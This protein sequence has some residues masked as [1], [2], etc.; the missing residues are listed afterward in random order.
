MQ[1]SDEGTEGPHLPQEAKVEMSQV[2]PRQDAGTCAERTPRLA[3]SDPTSAPPDTVPASYARRRSATR[4]TGDSG[5][6]DGLADRSD[7]Q[8]YG[9]FG[10][11]R[12]A[13][14]HPARVSSMSANLLHQFSAGCDPVDLLDLSIREGEPMHAAN[15]IGLPARFKC[16]A[17]M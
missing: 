1:S 9:V 15:A 10:R 17:L 11:T 7:A 12:P 5:H 2:Q 8:P 13:N 6:L 16:P 3:G 14:I 4:R